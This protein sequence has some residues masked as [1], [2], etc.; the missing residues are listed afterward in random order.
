M[1]ITAIRTYKC[2]K[3]DYDI[4]LFKKFVWMGR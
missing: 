3:N 1:D 4:R 2:I